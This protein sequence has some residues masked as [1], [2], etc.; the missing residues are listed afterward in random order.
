MVPEPARINTEAHF[1]EEGWT[2]KIRATEENTNEIENDL[3]N[4]QYKKENV[5]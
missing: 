2:S 1:W 5:K 4:P 3:K